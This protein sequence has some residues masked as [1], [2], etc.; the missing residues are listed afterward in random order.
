MQSY[1]QPQDDGL[2]MRESG[3][4][5]I[6]KLHIVLELCAQQQCNCAAGESQGRES[7]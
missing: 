5:V 1:L 7:A 3:S 4:W 2:P 6:E